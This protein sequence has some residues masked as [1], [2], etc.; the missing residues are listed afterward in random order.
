MPIKPRK[1][2]EKAIENHTTEVTLCCNKLVAVNIEKIQ[3]SNYFL[4]I[5]NLT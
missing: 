1:Y 4:V 5:F 3:S 2:N